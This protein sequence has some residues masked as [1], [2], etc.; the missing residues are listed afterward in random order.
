MSNNPPIYSNGA[1]SYER[2]YQ[3]P[4]PSAWYVQSAQSMLTYERTPWWQWRTRRRLL[5]AA[6]M[7]MRLAAQAPLNYERDY[8]I[9]H[10]LSEEGICPTKPS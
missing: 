6:F 3:Y 4:P 8:W 1:N 2:P 5:K 10:F 9:W 7:M